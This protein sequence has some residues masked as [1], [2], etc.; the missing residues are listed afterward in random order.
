MCSSSSR[1]SCSGQARR[2]TMEANLTENA[3][4]KWKRISEE[5]LGGSQKNMSTWAVLFICVKEIW[6]AFDMNDSGSLKGGHALLPP[7]KEQKKEMH[8]SPA[9]KTNSCLVKSANYLLLHPG[10]WDFS[11]EHKTPSS[12]PGHDNAPLFTPSWECMP[13]KRWHSKEKTNLW[14]RLVREILNYIA[15]TSF[16]CAYIKCLDLRFTFTWGR[17]R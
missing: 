8:F 15:Y 13:L 7:L 14:Q 11:F 5:P 12:V 3:L 2:L 10:V 4:L 1:L 17:C 6:H 16:L 9:A